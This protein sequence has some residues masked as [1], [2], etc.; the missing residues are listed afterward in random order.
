[1]ASSDRARGEGTGPESAR[2]QLGRERSR[3]MVQLDA[4]CDR[5]RR[6]RPHDRRVHARDALSVLP[7]RSRARALAYSR[8]CG[9]GAT[10]LLV[11]FLEMFLP[12]V[13][14]ERSHRERAH[15]IRDFFGFQVQESDG[16]FVPRLNISISAKTKMTAFPSGRNFRETMC[17]LTLFAVRSR[18]LLLVAARFRHAR[19]PRAT[20]AKNMTPVSLQAEP[21]LLPTAGTVTGAPRRLNATFLICSTRVPNPS[22]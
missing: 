18:D 12:A 16:G 19:E 7:A 13:H 2:A 9:S 6:S 14:R 15:T 20:A 10:A 8:S 11:G 21:R 17:F 1:M 3:Y 22:H 4:G 5:G